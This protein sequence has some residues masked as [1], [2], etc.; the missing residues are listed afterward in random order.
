MTG[1]G[2]MTPG[3]IRELQD[4]LRRRRHDTGLGLRSEMRAGTAERELMV[5]RLNQ[6]AAAGY[7]DE[8]TRAAR[9]GRALEAVTQAELDGLL[10]DVPAP[11]PGREPGRGRGLQLAGGVLLA[12]GGLLTMVA[13]PMWLSIRP[14]GTPLAASHG[15]LIAVCIICGLMMLVTGTVLA[16]G[17]GGGD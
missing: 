7:L 16:A 9:V 1:T 10:G 14:P 8:D 2:N 12:G 6:A 15:V 11:A 5:S 3:E 13:L 17:T 4:V